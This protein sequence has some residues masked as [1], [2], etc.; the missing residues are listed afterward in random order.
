MHILFSIALT[1]LQ[2]VTFGTDGRDVPVSVIALDDGC[3]VVLQCADPAG[4]MS[5]VLALVPFDGSEPVLAPLDIDI[6][7]PTWTRGCGWLSD[8]SFAL[9]LSSWE[10]VREFSEIQ[11]Y[12]RD[13]DPADIIW[14]PEEGYLDAGDLGYSEI[15]SMLP[16]AGGSG[17]LMTA[18]LHDADSDDVLSKDLFRLDSHGD[19]LWVSEIPVEGWWMNP[20]VLRSMP[21]GGCVVGSD[22]DG[23]SSTLFVSRFDRAGDIQWSAEVDAR[24]EMTHSVQDILPARDDGTLLVGTTDMFRMQYHGLFV[25]LD[26]RGNIVKETLEYGMGHLVCNSGIPLEDRGGFLLTGWTG[27]KNEEMMHSVDMDPVLVLLD[28]FGN[29]MGW[30]VLPGP[31][32]YTDPLFILEAGDGFILVGSCWDE[33]DYYTADAFVEF[34]DQRDIPEDR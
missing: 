4:G 15:S 18:D 28:P 10:T 2:G 6:D 8:D 22:E 32:E 11:I 1:L 3:A 17:Y 24:G 23:F 9:Q 19:T 31:A 33:D 20:D 27:E 12:S 16:L 34:I 21:D 30:N 25:M 29:V 5:Y 13:T 26:A 7:D 14:I